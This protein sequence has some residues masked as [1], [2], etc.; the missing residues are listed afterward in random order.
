MS[1]DCLMK[2]LIQLDNK[3]QCILHAISYENLHGKQIQIQTLQIFNVSTN[4]KSQVVGEITVN[5][6]SVFVDY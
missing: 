1:H 6:I 5:P 3:V 2:Q 4:I